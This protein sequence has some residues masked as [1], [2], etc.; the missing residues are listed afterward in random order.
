MTKV[1]EHTQEGAKFNNLLIFIYQLAYLFLSL[2]FP[3]QQK[4]VPFLYLTYFSMCL[5]FYPVLIA[6]SHITGAF[7]FYFIFLNESESESCSVV[8]NSL[9]AHGLYSAWNSPGQNT[10]AQE[11]WGG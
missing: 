2:L 11:Y 4:E 9:R 6:R 1:T 3:S 10:G 7:I 8:S 5:F